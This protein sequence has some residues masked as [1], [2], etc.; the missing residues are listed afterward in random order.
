MNDKQ[1]SH[2]ALTTEG[3][4]KV[5]V[6]TQQTQGHRHND[7]CF[8]P[9]GEIVVLSEECDSGEREGP[10]STCGCTRSLSGVMT[11]KSTTTVEV[12]EFDGTLVD[13]SYIVEDM[14]R[15]GGW[16]RIMGPDMRVE[17]EFKAETMCDVA[18]HFP[19]GAVL[20]RR[21]DVFQQR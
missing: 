16:E 12:A 15:R 9:E 5:L 10:D 2:N 19:V 14:L 17:A 4:L 13:M 11:L 18:A 6:A 8:V 21:G 20:E 7:F 1:S 3:P